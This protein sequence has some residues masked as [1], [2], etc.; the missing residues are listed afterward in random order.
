M[1]THLI[2][3]VAASVRYEGE[4]VGRELTLDAEFAGELISCNFDLAPGETRELNREIVQLWVDG[5]N[6]DFSGQLQVTERDAIH[7]GSGRTAVSWR[8]ESGAA[9]DAQR[10]ERIE[11]T[12]VGRKGRAVTGLFFVTLRAQIVAAKRY[13]REPDSGWLRVALDEDQS[14]FSLPESLCVELYRLSE[15]RGYFQIKEGPYRGKRASVRLKRDGSST[16][17]ERDPRGAAVRAIYSISRKTLTVHNRV[18]A[19]VDHPLRP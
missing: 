6:L 7:P 19:T 15:G 18:Y 8:L 3:L 12:E 4:S 14:V 16:L 13:V 2:T 11:V 5:D 9:D 1:A 17:S 10:V